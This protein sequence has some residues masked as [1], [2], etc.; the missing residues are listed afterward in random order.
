MI[1]SCWFVDPAPIHNSL[2]RYFDHVLAAYGNYAISGPTPSLDE[3]IIALCPL[4]QQTHTSL[5]DGDQ[6]PIR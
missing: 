6:T 3:S 2:G 5:P 1:T 4:Q